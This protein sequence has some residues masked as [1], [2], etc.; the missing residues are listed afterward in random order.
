MSWLLLILTFPL[1]LFSLQKE[2]AVIHECIASQ[3]IEI[4]ISAA[5]FSSHIR[6]EASSSDETY[7]IVHILP[8]LDWN[9]WGIGYEIIL[10][11]GSHWFS[12]RYDSWEW[13]S[14]DEVAI[15]PFLDQSQRRLM[16]MGIVPFYGEANYRIYNLTRNDWE[17]F[18]RC[19]RS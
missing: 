10:D 9:F 15:E 12:E 14:G 3:N 19:L 6:S 13:E 1:M 8:Q 2:E 5:L 4:L 16:Q 17:E 11:D 7:Q 18:I